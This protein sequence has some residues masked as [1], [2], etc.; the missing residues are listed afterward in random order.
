[1]SYIT[2]SQ[3]PSLPRKRAAWG[4]AGISLIPSS[5]TFLT[6]HSLDTFLNFSKSQLPRRVRIAR[7]TRWSQHVSRKSGSTDRAWHTAEL[8]KCSSSAAPESTGPSAPV[9]WKPAPAPARC[10]FLGECP[11]LLHSA[12]NHFD[13]RIRSNSTSSGS[14]SAHLNP[15]LLSP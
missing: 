11:L 10:S 5:A 12:Y 1:M 7:V 2:S 6:C 8:N 13:L 3:R 14:T 15:A 4:Q 9:C